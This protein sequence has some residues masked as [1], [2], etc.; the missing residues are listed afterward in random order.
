M[1]KMLAELKDIRALMILGWIEGTSYLLLLFIAMP[2]KYIWHREL[3][4]EIVGA[5]HGALFVIFIGLLLF[6]WIFRKMPFG[7]F[8]RCGIGAVIPF[9]PFLYEGGL[10][11]LYDQKRSLTNS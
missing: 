11:R 5:A 4:V 7:L 8:M 3:A 6:V 1:K 9:G 10:K 2:L